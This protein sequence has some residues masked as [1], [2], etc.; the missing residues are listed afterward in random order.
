MALPASDS[1]QHDFQ[2]EM[3]RAE[4]ARQ[5]GNE[6]M[7]R[8]CAR[9]AAGHAVRAYLR[10]HNIVVEG[11][12]TYVLL[13]QLTRM[14]EIAPEISQ[15]AGYLLLRITPEG[16]LP[17]DVDLIAVTYHLYASLHPSQNK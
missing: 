17:I 6:G 11:S 9:R 12:S 7:A 2:L 10:L 8:V 4:R 15:L 3:L 16:K 14:R 1:W 13:R 5:D